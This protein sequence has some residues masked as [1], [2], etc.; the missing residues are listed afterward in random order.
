MLLQGGGAASPLRK[1][2]ARFPAHPDFLSYKHIRKIAIV[3]RPIDGRAVQP[4]RITC[5]SS[6]TF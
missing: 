5:I 1:R 3:H 6:G 2:P 4:K